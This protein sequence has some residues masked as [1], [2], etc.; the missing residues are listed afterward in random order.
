MTSVSLRRWAARLL[1]A[2]VFGMN[3]QSAVVFIARPQT[4][5][6]GFEL[7]GTAGLYLIQA[8][9]ILFLMWNATF[10]P[11]IIHPGRYR[12]LF[13][14]VIAQQVIGLGGESWLLAGLPGSHPALVATA[15]RFIFF[16]TLGLVA[17]VAAFLLSRRANIRRG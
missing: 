15:A 6:S 12:L 5:A 10:P 4:Y 11:V 8:M 16:D 2:A 7:S 1:V 17:L 14:V 3:V 13:G 9:G